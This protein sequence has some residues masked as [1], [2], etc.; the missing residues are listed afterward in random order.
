VSVGGGLGGEEPADEAAAFVGGTDAGGG[1]GF[2]GAGQE[3]Q[4]V[5]EE[6]ATL[7]GIAGWVADGQ[8]LGELAGE[9]GGD[10]VEQSCCADALVDAVE[11]PG[12][13]LADVAAQVAV[14]ASLV[15]FVAGRAG[16]AL[17]ARV[18]ALPAYQ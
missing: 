4:G 9:Q 7:V 1:V 3:G 8:V 5:G 12:G 2:G 11:E 6:P 17:R 10:R 14:A 18:A 16:A 13:G 15:E